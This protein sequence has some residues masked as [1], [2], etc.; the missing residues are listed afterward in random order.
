MELWIFVA[1]TVIILFFSWWLS[2]KDKR[3][4]GIWRFFSFESLLALVLLNW[5]FWFIDPFS[6]LQILSWM[7]LFA[8]IFVTSAGFYFLLSRGRPRGNFENTTKLVED[9]I[10]G[11]IRHPLYCSLMVLGFGIFLK[12]VNTLTTALAVVNSLAL[13]LTA[14]VEEEEMRRKFGP[15]YAAYMKKT[16]MFIPFIL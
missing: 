2:I 16:K 7:L 3:Y 13:Y 5:R 11:F 6:R 14:K 1:G 4:H 12:N 8:S 10:Y 15:D 9:G